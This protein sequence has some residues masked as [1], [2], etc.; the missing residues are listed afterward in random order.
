[1]VLINQ[2]IMKRVILGFFLFGFVVQ[3]SSAQLWK[4]RRYEL[5]ANFGTSQLMGDIGGFTP[6]E[7]ALGFK[8]LTINNTRF[9][10][11][12]GMRYRILEDLSV[13]LDISYAFLHASDKKGSNEERDYEAS[14]SLFEPSVRGEYYFLKNKAE[15]LYRFT[16]KGEFFGSFLSMIDLYVYAGMAPAFY[17]VNPND[18][19]LPALDSDGGVTFVVPLGLGLNFLL[20]PN[21]LIGIDIGSRF[22]FT[23]YIDGYTSQYSKYNDRYYFMTVVFTHKLKTSEKGLPSFRK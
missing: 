8:D 15:G 13:K 19:L 4:L 6:G 14:T 16:K 9:A 11:G 7:N 3:I 23:D 20:T 2:V 10:L 21:N 12:A 1:M 22:T 18:N 5:T 17:K